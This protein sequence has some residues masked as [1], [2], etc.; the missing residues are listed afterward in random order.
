MFGDWTE[1]ECRG[2]GVANDGC[3]HDRNDS[4]RAVVFEEDDRERIPGEETDVMIAVLGACEGNP[5]FV[6][7]CGSSE[8]LNKMSDIEVMGD[9]DLDL[10]G[11][12][13][14]RCS[15]ER[16]S[17]LVTPASFPSSSFSFPF[18]LFPLSLSLRPSLTDKLILLPSFVQLSSSCFFLSIPLGNFILS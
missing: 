5:L 16:F 11:N 15:T 9:D 12:A 18:L 4:L 14:K 3:D 13:L 7:F 8:G 17:S 2:A 10:M 6:L 1:S